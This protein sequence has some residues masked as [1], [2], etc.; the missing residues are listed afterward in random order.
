M[1]SRFTRIASIKCPMPRIRF[2]ALDDGKCENRQLPAGFKKGR[3]LFVN[4]K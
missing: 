1:T 2:Q 4:K 3:L